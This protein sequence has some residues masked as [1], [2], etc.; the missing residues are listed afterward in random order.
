MTRVGQKDTKREIE[1]KPLPLSATKRVVL[2]DLDAFRAHLKQFASDTGSKAE[3]GRR[4]GVTGQFIDLLIAGKRKP[5]PKLL[6]AIG[7]R[8]K[9]MIEIEVEA[10]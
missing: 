4:L 7:A 3:L 8:P 5:G 10:E 2:L 6:K 1:T 9:L